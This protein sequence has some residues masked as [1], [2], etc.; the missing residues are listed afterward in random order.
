[1]SRL[2]WLGPLVG[3]TGVAIAGLSLAYR[4]KRDHEQELNR[5]MRI[6]HRMVFFDIEYDQYGWTWSLDAM[7]PEGYP[8]ATI[9]GEG[10]GEDY[11]QVVSAAKRHID[12]ELA[13]LG[14]LPVEPDRPLPP[15]PPTTVNYPY[16][17]YTIKLEF[18]PLPIGRVEWSIFY[19]GEFIYSD[20]ASKEQEAR[21]AA[22]A[23]A[24]DL[25]PPEAM[26]VPTRYGVVIGDNC[27]EIG[28]MDLAHWVAVAAPRLQAAQDTREGLG[29]ILAAAFP[30]CD[31]PEP[32]SIVVEDVP[33]ANRILAAD[34][35][36]GLPALRTN[37]MI[38]VAVDGAPSVW[39]HAAALIVGASGAPLHTGDRWAYGGHVV[40][41]APHPADGFVWRAWRAGQVAGPPA[42]EGSGLSHHA[43]AFDARKS[44]SALPDAI[45]VNP[46]VLE[47]S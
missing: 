36:Y 26:G 17:P 43:A 28:V 2:R 41:I 7:T 16:G 3:V 19:E 5:P 38:S 35:R 31:W 21:E 25:P 33:L 34:T 47:L 8:S 23:H 9:S 13:K 44:I 15:K 6:R 37:G 1:M 45:I 10:S 14:K 32:E 18:L 40:Q 4:V 39:D 27:D 20:T 29:E 12:Q 46:Q 11:D 24:S 30:D 22:E 42:L